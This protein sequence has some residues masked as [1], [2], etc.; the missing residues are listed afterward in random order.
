[1]M[2]DRAAPETVS[3]LLGAARDPNAVVR[4]DTDYP[5]GSIVISMSTTTPGVGMLVAWAPSVYV[6]EWLQTT[7][8]RP[9]DGYKVTL[10]DNDGKNLGC[11][12][13]GPADLAQ[14]TGDPSGR[15]GYLQQ[16]F[17]DDLRRFGPARVANWS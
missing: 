12:F 13:V 4:V 9:C 10:M 15:T 14:M 11:T 7:E 17:Q 16:K 5:G 3:A 8:Q 6:T 1:M 2:Q